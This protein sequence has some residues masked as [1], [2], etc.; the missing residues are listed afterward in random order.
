VIHYRLY[1]T[2]G[3][4]LCEQAWALLC[5]AG[6]GPQTEQADIVERPEWLA[7]YRFSIPVLQHLGSGRELH[8]PFDDGDLKQF[9]SSE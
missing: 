3:C 8:W 5:S 4:H 7:R 2:D 9:M 1:S 6:I